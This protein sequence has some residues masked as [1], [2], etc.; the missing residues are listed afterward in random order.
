MVKRWD[1]SI[2]NLPRSQWVFRT[3]WL[4]HTIGQILKDNPRVTHT[5]VEG[6]G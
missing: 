3:T 1:A 4:R 5:L 2:C 6:F